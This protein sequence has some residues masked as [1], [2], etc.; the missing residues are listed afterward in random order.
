MTQITN[1]FTHIQFNLFAYL[2][3]LFTQISY[4]HISL[5]FLLT[6]LLIFQ[7][8]NNKHFRCL[9]DVINCKNILK[10]TLYNRKFEFQN[11][12]NAQ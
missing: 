9:L 2:L 3:K 4:Y 6:I 11:S 7:L 5:A 1:N 10:N 12:K 8:A